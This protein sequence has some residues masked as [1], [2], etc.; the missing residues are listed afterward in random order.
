MGSTK[1]IAL[2]LADSILAIIKNGVAEEG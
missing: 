1:N 2:K